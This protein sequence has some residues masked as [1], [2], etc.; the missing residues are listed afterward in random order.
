MKHEQRDVDERELRGDS[1]DDETAKKG[2]IRSASI[3]CL[4]AGVALLPFARMLPM[5]LVSTGLLSTGII[6]LIFG[7]RL[8]PNSRSIILK[9]ENHVLAIAA[10][11]QGILTPTRLAL[12]ARMTID[13]ARRELNKLVKAGACR[14]NVIE[15]D[16]RI[17]YEF[18]DFRE[19]RKAD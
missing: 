4:V 18:P 19:R 17:E 10:K 1:S 7:P 2:G 5:M 8:L 16:G 15:E 14:T 12:E 9:R 11:H 13:E 6:G 3:I